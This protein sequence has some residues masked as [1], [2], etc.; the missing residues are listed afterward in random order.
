MLQKSVVVTF[1]LFLFL[2]FSAGIV[3]AH[4]S[5]KVYT[6]DRF[7]ISAQVLQTNTLRVTE[8]EV[9]HFSGGTFSF[10]KR[11]LPTDNIDGINVLS[12]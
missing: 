10:V 8:T 3:S 9:F 2:L 6:A 12:T 7:D 1:L 5:D 11:E 4:T